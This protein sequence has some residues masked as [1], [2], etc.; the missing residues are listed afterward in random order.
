V[1][2]AAEPEG[3]LISVEDSGEGIP[4]EYH[5]QI[6]EKFAQVELRELGH[7]TDTGLGLTFC[8]MAVEALGGTIAVESEPGKG[9]RFTLILPGAL[10]KE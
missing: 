2:P 7:K 6:F 8:R 4:K 9:S 5:G 1:I 3:V 10:L